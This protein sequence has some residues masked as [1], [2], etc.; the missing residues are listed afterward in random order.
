MGAAGT[1]G[2]TGLY[3]VTLGEAKVAGER[4]MRIRVYPI[5]LVTWGKVYFWDL[6]CFCQLR[7]CWR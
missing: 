6:R 3:Q 4:V 7:C 5:F 1:D 2:V